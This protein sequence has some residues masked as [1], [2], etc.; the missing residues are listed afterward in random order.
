MK[1]SWLP[2]LGKRYGLLLCG[3][4][5]VATGMTAVYGCPLLGAATWFILMEGPGFSN[6]LHTAYSNL[7]PANASHGSGLYGLQV[8]CVAPI[9]SNTIG[10]RV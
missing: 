8:L 7:Q 5:F 9:L 1:S 2:G 3:S 6:H 4:G 10:S